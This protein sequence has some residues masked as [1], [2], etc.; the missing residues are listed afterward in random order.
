M[1]NLC[2]KIFVHQQV[3]RLGH[4]DHIVRD[5]FEFYLCRYAALQLMLLQ[6]SLRQDLIPIEFLLLI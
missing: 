3:Q 5:R 2:G 6:Q 1:I 4:N